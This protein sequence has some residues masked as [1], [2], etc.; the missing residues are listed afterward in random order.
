MKARS[1]FLKKETKEIFEEMQE[2]VDN[3]T[4][5]ELEILRSHCRGNVILGLKN[6][7]LVNNMIMGALEK[8]IMR[9]YLSKRNEIVNTLLEIE[10]Y[11]NIAKEVETRKANMSPEDKEY[12]LNQE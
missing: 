6:I 8:Y 11:A 7:P 2:R 4:D 12:F 9:Q 3:L 5:K 10:Y 1:L